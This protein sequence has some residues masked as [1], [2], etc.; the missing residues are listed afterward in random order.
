MAPGSA[1]AI[2][3]GGGASQPSRGNERAIMSLA[4]S[5]Y[6]CQA[7]VA[8]TPMQNVIEKRARTRLTRTGCRAGSCH[9]LEPRRRTVAPTG[10][11][12]SAQCADLDCIELNAELITPPSS[13]V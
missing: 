4:T 12:S 5:P 11:S 13:L 6:D 3:A 8:T 1:C 9:S 2:G 10:G 7:N